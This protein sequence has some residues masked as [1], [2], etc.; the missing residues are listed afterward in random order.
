MIIITLKVNC[1]HTRL[2]YGVQEAS[3]HTHLTCVLILR[4]VG[5]ITTQ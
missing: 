2:M 4:P 5:M 3:F 1:G